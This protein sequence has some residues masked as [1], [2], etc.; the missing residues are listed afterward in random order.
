VSKEHDPRVGALFDGYPEARKLFEVVR[1][2]IESLGP[3]SVEGMK[4]Q[5]SLGMRRK[6]ALV[7]LPQFWTNKR[8]D[9]SITLT[10]SLERQV[11]DE[12]IAESVEPEAGRWTHHVVIEHERDFDDA[13]RGCL[14]EAY[15]IGRGGR[16]R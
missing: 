2:F 15:E 3:V 7:W 11:E 13:V 8:P 4:M 6:F 9:T 1:K 12:L 16:A 14:R 10:F 5:V